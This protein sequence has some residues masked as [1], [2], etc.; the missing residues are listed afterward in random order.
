MAVLYYLRESRRSKVES[1]KVPPGTP[2][3]ANTQKQEVTDLVLE[4]NT[5]LTNREAGNRLP[6][7]LFSRLPEEDFDK[8]ILAL[9]L[10]HD[11]LIDKGHLARIAK[12]SQLTTWEATERMKNAKKCKKVAYTLVYVIFFL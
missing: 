5:Q 10:T 1:R 9:C 8:H 3:N 6:D 2:I 7:E 4:R 12:S 11:G